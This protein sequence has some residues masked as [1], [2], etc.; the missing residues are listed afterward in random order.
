MVGGWWI[1]VVRWLVAGGLPLWC[2]GL[3][4][5]L[6]WSGDTPAVMYRLLVWSLARTAGGRV[7]SAAG[8]DRQTLQWQPGW[9]HKERRLRNSSNETFFNLLTVVSCWLWGLVELEDQYHAMRR[10]IWCGVCNSC[11]V[12][13]NNNF[14]KFK[15]N[16]NK[17]KLFSFLPQSIRL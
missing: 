9:P 1:A 10:T 12:R 2:G 11:S 14:A 7:S 15:L 5:V 8:A 13:L 17:I 4:E 16:W 6:C 3:C